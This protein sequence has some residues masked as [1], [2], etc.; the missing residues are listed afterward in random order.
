MAETWPQWIE[1]GE[2]VAQAADWI[3]WKT[4]GRA[5]IVIAVGTN[6]VAIAKPRELDAE[7]AIAILEDVQNEIARA[8]RELDS[9]RITHLALSL[10]PR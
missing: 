2:H 4:Q 5:R 10:H 6:S 3:R 1:S 8:L 9:R 7:D